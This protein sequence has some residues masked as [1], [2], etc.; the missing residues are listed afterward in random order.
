MGP[1]RV[2][3][4]PG[5][6]TDVIYYQKP[7]R[8]K[9]TARSAFSNQRPN[10]HSKSQEKKSIPEGSISLVSPPIVVSKP[11][12]NADTGENQWR[13]STSL[14]S[15]HVYESGSL[16]VD[17][18][19][20]LSSLSIRLSSPVQGLRAVSGKEA[21]DMRLSSDMATLENMGLSS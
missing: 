3:P 19:T 9:E 4:Q 16:S 7:R 12:N 13:Q 2:R 18:S 6:F 5:H 17:F 1:G 21:K 11:A 15:V 8:G 10:T 20:C 14:D